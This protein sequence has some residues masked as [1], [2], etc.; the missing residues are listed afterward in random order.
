MVKFHAD[1]G[2]WQMLP[3]FIGRIVSRRG[4]ELEQPPSQF[5]GAGGAEYLRTVVEKA[6][7]KLD[8]R[9]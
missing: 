5:Q 8:K 9:S 7:V 1:G 4:N 3:S 2:T 6:H